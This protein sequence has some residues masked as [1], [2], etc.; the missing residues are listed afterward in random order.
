MA[1][2]EILEINNQRALVYASYYFKDSQKKAMHVF[3]KFF[4]NHDSLFTIDEIVSL[5]HPDNGISEEQKKEWIDLLRDKHLIH[6]G[7][8]QG[9]TLYQLS[10]S[11]LVAMENWLI[12]KSPENK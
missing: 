1:K 6:K 4:Q 10:E 2:E 3:A 12:K 7:V 9:K 8:Y 11:Q 5:A